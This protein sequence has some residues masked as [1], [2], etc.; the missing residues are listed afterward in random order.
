M[1]EQILF[2][3]RFSCSS[4]RIHQIEKPTTEDRNQDHRDGGQSNP[5]IHFGAPALRRQITGDCWLVATFSRYP[6]EF[7]RP[8]ENSL[9]AIGA[10]DYP[11]FVSALRIT[12]YRMR[13]K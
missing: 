3:R 6:H 2:P 1:A 12:S 8:T 9:A 13:F 10:W 5:A 7:V 11:A 4:R